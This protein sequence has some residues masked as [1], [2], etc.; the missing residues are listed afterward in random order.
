MDAILT[1]VGPVGCLKALSK[2]YKGNPL[3]MK[4]LPNKT[5]LKNRYSTL[6]EEM[7]DTLDAVTPLYCSFLITIVAYYGKMGD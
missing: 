6:R 4:L 2:R 7:K 5:Q 1:G 3:M